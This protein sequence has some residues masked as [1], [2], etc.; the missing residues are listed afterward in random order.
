MQDRS[1]WFERYL[2]GEYPWWDEYPH[3]AKVIEEFK[4]FLSETHTPKDVGDNPTVVIWYSGA[5]YHV[6][7]WDGEDTITV[8][9]VTP[10]QE[11]WDT[12]GISKWLQLLDFVPKFIYSAYGVE[13]IKHGIE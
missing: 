7:A 13:N 3:K 11:R 6:Y 4:R 9:C 1:K 5:K 8:K 10:R 12:I 2:R